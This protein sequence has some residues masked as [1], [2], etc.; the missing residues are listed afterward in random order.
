MSTVKDTIAG[1]AGGIRD[2]VALADGRGGAHAAPLPVADALTQGVEGVTPET[3][4]HEWRISSS[5]T[6]GR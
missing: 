1:S 5:A 6:R 3:L 2:A 4:V